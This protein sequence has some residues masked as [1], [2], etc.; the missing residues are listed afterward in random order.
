MSQPHPTNALRSGSEAF[1]RVL[2]GMFL[3]IIAIA[4]VF[5]N[6]NWY[7][8]VTVLMALFASRE[9]HRMVRSPAQRVA[10]DLMPVHVQTA[11]TAGAVAC[12]VT[13]LM[14]RLAPLAFLLLAAGA[15][16]AFFLARRRDDNPFW[17]AGGVIYIGL[18]SLAL[19]ALRVYPPQGALVV[20][21][22]FLIV[23]ATDTGALVF[24]KLIGGRKMAPRL[25]PGKTWAGTLGGSI[26]AAVVFALYI[27][28]F[29]FNLWLAMLFAFV[30][31]FAAHGGDLFESLVKRRFGYKD[32][33]G[34]IP[35][36]GGVLDRMDSMFAASVILALLI[37]GLHINP[38]FGGHA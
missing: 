4:L 1:L 12:A 20:L 7:A 2:F 23:W 8:A 3:A 9:W 33:G 6:P 35:G 29:G 28:F 30:F 19:V 34:L 24:G 38:L 11:V 5:Y 31:S 15:V 32:S 27:A 10:A 25:S 17:H 13:A 22:L 18:P 37:F 36:H 21:G 26:T 14:L 16:A